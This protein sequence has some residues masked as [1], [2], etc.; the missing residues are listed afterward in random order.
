MREELLD[1]LLLELFRQMTREEQIKYLASLR[2]LLTD[3][4]DG[5]SAQA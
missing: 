3:Q 2:C 4:S 1:S 5:V